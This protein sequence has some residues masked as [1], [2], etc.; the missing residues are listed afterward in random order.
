MARKKIFVTR[1]HIIPDAI[2]YLKT[3]FDVDVWTERSAPPRNYLIE[4]ATTSDGILTEITDIID[5][6]LL[7]STTRLKIVANRA[8]GMDNINIP[9]ASRRGVLVANTPGVLHESCADFTM[10]LI[11]SLARKITYGDRQIRAGA[12][13]IFDQVPYVGTDVH[14]RSLGIIGMG[15][16]GSAVAKRARAFDMEVFYH[17]RTRKKNEEKN[18]GINWVETI[19]QILAESDYVSLHVPLTPETEYMIGLEQISK[20]KPTSFLINTTRGRTVDPQ[21]LYVGLS[22]GLIEGAAIDVTD[23]EPLPIDSPLLSLP[24]LLITPH[25]ASA[26]STTVKRMGLM[27]AENIRGAL[28][29]TDMPSCLNFEAVR[30]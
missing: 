1:E 5:E 24:N 7:Q 22:Q 6:E 13:K 25:I 2:E 9:E 21:A 17:S 8:V 4:K 16:I 26:S 10:G 28:S 15:L 30:K 11:L 18:L 3:F 14:E 19:D 23:P 12:W 20:M 29:G 27:A